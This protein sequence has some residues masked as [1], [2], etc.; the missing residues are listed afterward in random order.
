MLT[1]DQVAA[2]CT[3]MGVLGIVVFWF[4]IVFDRPGR[5]SE[6][7]LALVLLGLGG[8]WF[9]FLGTALR[10]KWIVIF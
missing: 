4:K 3:V 2:L 8:C 1:N 5:D 10:E 6:D 7:R 9:I